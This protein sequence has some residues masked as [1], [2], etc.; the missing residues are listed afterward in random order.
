MSIWGYVYQILG[1]ST[2]NNSVHQC[3]D[4]LFKPTQQL[5]QKHSLLGFSQANCSERKLHGVKDASTHPSGR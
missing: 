1:I 2:C 4:I 3:F 5:V